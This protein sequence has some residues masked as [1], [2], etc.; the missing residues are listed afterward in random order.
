MHTQHRNVHNEYQTNKLSRVGCVHL[1]QPSAC[2]RPRQTGM[3]TN[4]T[5][6]LLLLPQ[7]RAAVMLLLLSCR[8]CN[9]V[10]A[11]VILLMQSYCCCCAYATSVDEAKAAPGGVCWPSCA[12]LQHH[13]RYTYH[14]LYD[15]SADVMMS[16]SA[17]L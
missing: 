4:A 2:P 5:A 11:A 3:Y 8:C 12:D 7:M 9:H 17:V 13:C 10:V 6:M 1:V 14:C 15:S 16:Q